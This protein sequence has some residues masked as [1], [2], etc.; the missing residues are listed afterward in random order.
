LRLV[1][2]LHLAAVCV[3]KLERVFCFFHACIIPKR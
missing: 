2:E 1:T 3:F